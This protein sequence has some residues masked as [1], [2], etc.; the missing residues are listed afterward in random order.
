MKAV[1]NKAVFLFFRFK[2]VKNAR[3]ILG[4]RQG[5]RDDSR[6]YFVGIRGYSKRGG[7]YSVRIGVD[8]KRKAFG[9]GGVSKGNEFL[10]RQQEGR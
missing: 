1:C 9:K 2:A 3:G 5:I 8:S 10:A 6:G 4:Y 7:F